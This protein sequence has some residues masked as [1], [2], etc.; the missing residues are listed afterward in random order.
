[1]SDTPR[2]NGVFLEFR[3]SGLGSRVSG[4]GHLV[5]DSGFRVSGFGLLV[6]GFGFGSLVS[7]PALRM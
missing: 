7:D 2:G 1:V 4:F 3:I 6:A 5:P